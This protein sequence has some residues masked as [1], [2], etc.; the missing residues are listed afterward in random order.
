MN[1]DL[2]SHHS[3]SSLTRL[4]QAQLSGLSEMLVGLITLLQMKCDAPIG[5]QDLFS[6]YS[7]AYARDI[8]LRPEGPRRPVTVRRMPIAAAPGIPSYEVPNRCFDMPTLQVSF[9]N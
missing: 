8:A 5:Y 7:T 4:K 9:H 2:S 1:A 6:G 3:K